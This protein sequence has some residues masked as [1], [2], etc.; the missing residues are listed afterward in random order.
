LLTAAQV[1]LLWTPVR[2]VVQSIGAA[3]YA[4]G[5]YS[6]WLAPLALAGAYFIVPKIAGRALPNYEVAPLAFWLLIFVGTWTG[7]RHLVGGPVP[8]W[9]PTMA[10]VG[11]ALLVYHYVVVALN[12]RIV[13]GSGGTALKY[14]RFAL[15]AYLLSGLLAFATSFRG[16]AALTQFT[17]VAPALEQ[18]A[19]Y[20]AVSMFFFGTIHFMVPRLIGRPWASAGL[21]SAHAVT[22]MIGIAGS[23]IALLAAGLTQGQLLLDPKVGFAEIFQQLRLPLLINTAA[24]FTMLAANLLLVVNF[25][26]TVLV[27]GDEKPAEANLFRP[28]SALEVPAS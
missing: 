23:V 4:D 3:W 11:Y 14:V 16:V 22:I 8:V 5:L 18:L 25:F 20:G 7:G 9:V 15:L 2:G 26:R 6:L 24:Q 10:I 1:V 13:F 28:P 17:F 19:L 21:T 27:C 12:L